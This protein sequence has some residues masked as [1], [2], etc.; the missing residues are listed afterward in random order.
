MAK[1]YKDYLLGVRQ[2][3]QEHVSLL[4]E[5]SGDSFHVDSERLNVQDVVEELIKEKWFAISEIFDIRDLRYI[6]SGSHGSAFDCGNGKI[7]KITNDESEFDNSSAIVGMNIPH[8]MRVY[9]LARLKKKKVFFIQYKKYNLLRDEYPDLHEFYE[10]YE[11]KQIIPLG[12]MVMSYL[13]GDGTFKEVDTTRLDAW[14]R[15]QGSPIAKEIMGEIVQFLSSRRP[16]KELS[17]PQRNAIAVTL[18]NTSKVD[19]TL[20]SVMMDDEDPL[21]NQFMR[22]FSDI[23]EGCLMMFKKA[24]VDFGDYHSGNI[25]VD[26]NGEFV[27]FDLGETVTHKKARNFEIIEGKTLSI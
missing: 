2:K 19:S 3:A 26:D 22:L 27:L 10:A 1:T 7:L 11:L 21:G 8:V 24:G 12:E 25:A 16:F 20:L 5:K 23:I 17:E 13:K 15:S 14:I 18:F 9:K 4:M 6:D